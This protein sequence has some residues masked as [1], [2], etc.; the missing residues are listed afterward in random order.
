MTVVSHDWNEALARVWSGVTRVR[1]RS[2]GTRDQDETLLTVD[3]PQDLRLLADMMR[4]ENASEELRCKCGGDLVFELYRGETLVTS[5]SFHHGT[6][7]RWS[8]GWPSD[9]WLVPGGDERLC[10]WLA[11]HGLTQPLEQLQRARSR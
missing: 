3:R 1:V 2:A 5:V 10:R 4:V 11:E 7:L 9:G 8:D 6:H